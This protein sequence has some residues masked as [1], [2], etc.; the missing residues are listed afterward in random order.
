MRKQKISFEDELPITSHLEELRKRL[1]IVLIVVA[2]SFGVAYN[3]SEQVLNIIKR[4]IKDCELIFL[5]PAE[6][7][8]THLKIGFMVAILISA[9]F[10][11]YQIWA[12]VS[13]GLLQKEKKYTLPVV[14]FGTLLFILGVLFSY[15][16][17][18][19]LGL[20][21]LLNYKTAGLVA[22]ISVGPYVT[23]F[24]QMSFLFG[25]IFELPLVLCFLTKIGIVRPKFLSDV[26]KYAILV[27]FIVSAILTPPDVVSQV[28]MAI[29]LM[30][31]YEISI[32]G[33]KIIYRKKQKEK[34]EQP[35]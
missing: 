6:P 28:L 16:A 7:F 34:A 35:E 15:F 17:M 30:I 32:I 27:I 22:R 5:S 4:P 29:P 31:L 18:L 14:F 33:S 24:G 9:P 21:F 11:F 10:I 19:P 23:F 12:F 13:P 3:F 26:R 1:I 25:L 2:L 8:F 20:Q